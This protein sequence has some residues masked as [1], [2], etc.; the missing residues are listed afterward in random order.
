MT[1]NFYKLWTSQIFSQVTANMLA[2]VLLIRV[3]ELTKSST[4]VGLVMVVFTLPSLLLGIFAGVFVDRWSKKTVLVVTN[5]LQAVVI[6]SFLLI[7]DKLWPIYTLV[8]LYSLIDEFF[9]PAESSLIPYIVSKKNL[10]TANSLFFFTANSALLIGYGIGGPLIKFV[11]RRA[12]FVIGSAFLLLA[13]AAVAWLP[14]DP[15]ANKRNGKGF[16]RVWS[17]FKDGFDFLRGKKKILYPFVFY[18]AIQMIVVSAVVLFPQYATNILHS[19]LNDAGLILVVPAGLGAFSGAYLVKRILPLLGR[20]LAVLWSLFGIAVIVLGLSFV[21]PR[22]S[23]AIYYVIPLF[24]LLGLMVVSI[25]ASI[26]AF[27]QENV[28][29][30]FRARILGGLSAVATW[31]AGLPVLLSATLADIFGVTQVLALIGFVVLAAAFY[32]RK[33]KYVNLSLVED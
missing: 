9:G 13:T 8:F 21:I 7:G 18:N 22:T 3:Y 16:D 14:R 10:P 4:A 11:G 6:L 28:P 25:N 5:F 26:L 17:D 15:V 2:F 12:P 33:D 20:R 19:D 23:Q 24:Y 30:E 27:L 32:L 29:F 1:L 31:S